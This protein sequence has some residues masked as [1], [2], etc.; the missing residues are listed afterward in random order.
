VFIVLCVVYFQHHRDL[1]GLCDWKHM[2]ITLE[3]EENTRAHI[4]LI[5]KWLN[6]EQWLLQGKNIIYEN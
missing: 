4:Q 3:K 2:S 6:L 5:S 1:I